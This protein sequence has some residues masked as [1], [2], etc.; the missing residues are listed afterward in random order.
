MS[1]GSVIV[2]P[3]SG[4]QGIGLALGRPPYGAIVTVI[5][6]PDS[7]S[8]ERR[9]LVEH[10]GAEVVLIHDDGNIGDC[11]QRCL[12]TALGYAKK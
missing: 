1:P 7:V 10:Y 5:V 9:K 12:D 3:T 4:N 11:I 8:V 6:M 2:E